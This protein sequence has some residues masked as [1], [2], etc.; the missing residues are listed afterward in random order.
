[1]PEIRVEVVY[2]LP[3]R[4]YIRTL[5]LAQGS[6][7][8]QAIV[9]SKLLQL[10]SDIDLEHNK[11]GLYGRPAKLGDVINDGDRVE[12]YRPL[13]ADPKEWRRQRADKAQKNR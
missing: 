11:V 13:I 3:E 5:L 1:M 8:L 7:V 12:I 6:T 10:R 9:A 2:A 4:Q